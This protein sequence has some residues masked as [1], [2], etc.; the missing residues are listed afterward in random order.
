MLEYCFSKV[1][2]ILECNDNNLAKIPNDVKQRTQAE[3]TDNSEKSW[4]VSTKFPPHQTHLR[5]W[6]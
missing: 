2:T 6:W 4:Y 3:E 1:F 5:T